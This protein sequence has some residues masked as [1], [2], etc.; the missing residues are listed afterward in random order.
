MNTDLHKIYSIAG[1]YAEALSL[2]IGMYSPTKYGLR[3]LATEL[4]HEFIEAKLRIKVTVITSE[5][6]N[7]LLY[8]LSSLKYYLYFH[9][10]NNRIIEYS[11]YVLLQQNISPGIVFTELFQK[12]AKANPK[13]VENWPILKSQDIAE[14]AMYALGTP[15]G[16]EV[17]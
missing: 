8:P 15:D 5:Y 3:A 9:T 7:F 14:A 4:R 13:A 6:L 11:I 17:I 16:V 10:L 2:P 1:L 12:F